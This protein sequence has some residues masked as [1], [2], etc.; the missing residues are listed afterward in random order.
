MV[1]ALARRFGG[2]PQP[3]QVA[4][5]PLRS[6]FAIA[7]E[8]AIEGCVR[9]TYGA[10]LAEHQAQTASDPE[11]R[12]AL[13]GIADDEMRHAL[14]AHRVAEW[15]EPQLADAERQALAT[16]RTAAVI[17]LHAELDTGLAPGEMAALGW[18]SREVAAELIGRMAAA[19]A[20]A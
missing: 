14:L 19:L 18:P 10:L 16:A 1:A 13:R 8:N 12:A 17:Q 11:V 6:R 2:D 20:V 5:L 15:L 9:E 7:L 4:A 3:P